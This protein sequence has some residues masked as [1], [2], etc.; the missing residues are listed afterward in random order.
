[1]LL[2]A[3]T[4]PVSR[5]LSPPGLTKNF[6]RLLWSSQMTSIRAALQV[7]SVGSY[8]AL[9]SG[10]GTKTSKYQPL[11]TITNIDAGT[12]SGLAFATEHRNTLYLK[13]PGRCSYM[14]TIDVTRMILRKV[15]LSRSFW[16]L[17]AVWSQYSCLLFCSLH[18]RLSKPSSHHLPLLG[19]LMVMVMELTFL[20]TTGVPV[21]NLN[22]RKSRHV[23]PR[24]SIWR[25][26]RL[27]LLRMSFVKWANFP[28][29]CPDI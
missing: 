10:T 27:V 21:E 11:S 9:L 4:P 20:R 19:K 28:F 23:S 17:L 12:V 26:S 24:S 8:S 1:M 5:S 3:T 2:A 13:I 18:S 29:S 22:R 25:K 6:V 7:I 14:R 16:F 15:S